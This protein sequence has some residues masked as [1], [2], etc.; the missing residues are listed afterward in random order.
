M[1]A[2]LA[3][4]HAIGCSHAPVADHVSSGPSSRRGTRTQELPRRWD[5]IDLIVGAKLYEQRREVARTAPLPHARG[6]LERREG[7]VKT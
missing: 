2:T 3:S 4:W 6:R 7:V 5:P 1:K